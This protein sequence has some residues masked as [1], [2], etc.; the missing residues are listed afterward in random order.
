VS[1]MRLP[2]RHSEAMDV[3]PGGLATAA[4]VE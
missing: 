4:A 3:A 1:A 2:A